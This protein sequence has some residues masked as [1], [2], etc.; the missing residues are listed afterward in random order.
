MDPVKYLNGL[1]HI[2]M[3]LKYIQLLNSTLQRWE[4]LYGKFQKSGNPPPLVCRQNPLDVN[5][6]GERVVL[7]ITLEYAQL[8]EILTSVYIRRHRGTVL[9]NR[10]LS[11][12][13]KKVEFSHR[14]GHKVVSSL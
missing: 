13:A 6:V 1:T 7:Q 5:S 8:G 4:L 10:Q 11:A 12:L 9:D 3:H 2:S 14:Y